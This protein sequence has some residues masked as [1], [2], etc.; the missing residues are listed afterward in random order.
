ML[1]I[2]LSWSP[3]HVYIVRHF[4]SLVLY[5]FYLNRDDMLV[6]LFLFVELVQIEVSLVEA[7]IRCTF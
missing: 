5:N 1:Y 3:A 7:Q 4:I 2:C 6:Q